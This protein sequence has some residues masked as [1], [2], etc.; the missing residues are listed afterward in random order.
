M[1]C[2]GSKAA[3]AAAPVA[4]GSAPEGD[5]KITLLR[6]AAEETIGLTVKASKE[7][8]GFLVEGIKEEG[9][10]PAYNKTK[11]EAPDSQVKAGDVIVAVNSIFG[12][13]EAMK[14]ELSNMQLSLAIKRGGLDLPVVGG[15]AAAPAAEAGTTAEAATKAEAEPASEPLVEPAAEAAVEKQEAPTE[16]KQEEPAAPATEPPAAGTAAAEAEAS[17][18]EAPAVLAESSE[19]K[20]SVLVTPDEAPVAEGP[21]E[22]AADEKKSACC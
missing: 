16:E 21:Q 14:K 6:T 1:G 19:A 12:E 5:Y 11:E 2:G 17:P 7:P 8:V 22:V 9:L 13:I 3:E 20:G 18:A 4:S 15:A 10:V